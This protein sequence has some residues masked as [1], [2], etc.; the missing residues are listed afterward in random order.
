MPDENVRIVRRLMSA[1]NQRDVE[2]VVELMDPGVEFFAPQT[3]LS[4]DRNS[5]YQGHE[6][7]RRYFD[8]VNG[9]WAALQVMPKE[10]RSKESHVVAL[11]SIVG[12]RDGAAVEAEVA[13]AWKLRDGKVVWGRVYQEPGQALEDAGIS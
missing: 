7:M 1:F 3:A 5:S 12:E 10:F 4:V 9:V 2:E 13:W 6:G 11:G 8:D